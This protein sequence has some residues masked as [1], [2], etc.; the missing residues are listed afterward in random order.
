MQLNCCWAHSSTWKRLEEDV[1]LQ[2][3]DHCCIRYALFVARTHR[4]HSHSPTA[5]VVAAE[6]EGELHTADTRSHSAEA[7]EE[8][9][10]LLHAGTLAQTAHC[11]LASWNRHLVRWKSSLP[12]SQLSHCQMMV[13]CLQ[14]LAVAAESPGYSLRAADLP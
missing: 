12:N 11:T 9:T 13:P 14:L 6:L 8:R 1:E 3:E 7:V 2:Q 10:K 5:L 4:S